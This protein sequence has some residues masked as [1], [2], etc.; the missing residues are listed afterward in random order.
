[1]LRIRVWVFVA[2]ILHF[3]LMLVTKLAPS[4][5]GCYYKHMGQ[6]DRYFSGVSPLQKRGKCP[7]L[8]MEIAP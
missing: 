7:V 4:I 1:M 3:V 2:L 5:L 6:S 8:K